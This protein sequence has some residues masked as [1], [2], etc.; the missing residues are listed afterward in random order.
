MFSLV[1]RPV[2]LLFLLKL[3]LLE[4]MLLLSMEY[5]VYVSIGTCGV[6]YFI[7]ALQIAVVK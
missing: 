4:P 3:K 2:F 5:N 1:K 6:F 7:R